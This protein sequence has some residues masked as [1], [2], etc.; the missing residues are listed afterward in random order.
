MD[1][2]KHSERRSGEKMFMSGCSFVKNFQE[3]PRGIFSSMSG[4][5]PCVSGQR[6]CLATINGCVGIGLN[7]RSFKNNEKLENHGAYQMC[8]S[9]ISY[10]FALFVLDLV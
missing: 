10:S 3:Q 9:F 7:A 1:N 2:E 4:S 5:S 6:S 8:T